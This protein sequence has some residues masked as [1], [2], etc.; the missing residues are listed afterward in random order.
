[1][2]SATGLLIFCCIVGLVG[3]VAAIF[4]RGPT[5]PLRKKGHSEPGLTSFDDGGAGAGG[6]D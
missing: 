4:D 2:S 5:A 1:M 6:G 3:L